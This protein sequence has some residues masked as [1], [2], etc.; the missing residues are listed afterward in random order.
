M[1]DTMSR[2]HKETLEHLAMQPVVRRLN[3]WAEL[4]AADVN[5]VMALHDQ[6]E[7][8]GPGRELYV[9]GQP[10]HTPRFLASGWACRQRMLPDGRRQIIGFVT[11]GEGMG[12]CTRRNP[13]A[14]STTVTLTR[15]ETVAA[16]GVHAAAHSG[17]SPALAEALAMA[18]AFEEA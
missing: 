6:I 5:M 14:F 9:E 13:L 12:F 4:P 16:A 7:R 17:R 10:I 8:F 2:R 18:S 15:V 3:A 1:E 11:P